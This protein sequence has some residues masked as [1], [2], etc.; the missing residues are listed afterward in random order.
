MA[1]SRLAYMGAQRLVLS[2]LFVLVCHAKKS[3]NV[4]VDKMLAVTKISQFFTK[5]L[6]SVSLLLAVQSKN[7]KS[8]KWSAWRPLYKGS[9]LWPL[10]EAVSEI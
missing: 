6:Q 8:N 4:G 1:H 9:L 3:Q 2:H 5:L 10:M 7:R